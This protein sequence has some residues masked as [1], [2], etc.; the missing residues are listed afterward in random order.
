M[1]VTNGA[2]VMHSL[3]AWAANK[4]SW[5]PSGSSVPEAFLGPFMNTIRLPPLYEIRT[6][7]GGA[8]HH[9][10]Q[11]GIYIASAIACKSSSP[12][13]THNVSPYLNTISAPAPHAQGLIRHRCWRH[14]SCHC[15]CKLPICARKAASIPIVSL[16][17]VPIDLSTL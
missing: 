16:L 7:H 5:T 8:S 4:Q 12:L 13:L 17:G 11:Q 10:S 3:S 15:F 6:T 9:P 14:S 1:K 2:L